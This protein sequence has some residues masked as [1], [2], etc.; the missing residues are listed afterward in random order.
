MNMVSVSGSSGQL[1]RMNPNTPEEFEE[2][3]IALSKKITEFEVC[4]HAP[5][6]GSYDLSVHSHLSLSLQASTHY[7]SFLEGLF[8]SL[9]APR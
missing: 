2:F 7:T 5:Y 3:R 9:C 1:E 6:A 8:R 4:S